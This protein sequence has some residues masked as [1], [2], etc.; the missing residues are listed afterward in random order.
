M[1]GLE[2]VLSIESSCLSACDARSLFRLTYRVIGAEAPF[3]IIVEKEFSVPAPTD[4]GSQS[5][6]RIVS[7]QMIFELRLESHPRRAVTLPL[8]EDTTDVDGKR[9]EPEE[10]LAKEPLSL[11]GPG[12]RKGV[13]RCSELDCTITELRELQDVK[14]FGSR[15]KIVDLE[16]EWTSEL[17]QLGTPSIGC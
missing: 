8:I 5:L 4:D 17:G 12:L 14:G 7:G 1:V 3:L 15:E 9:Y 2:S 16:S 10:M 11:L 6:L 13:A